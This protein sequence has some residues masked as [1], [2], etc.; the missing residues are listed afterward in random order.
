MTFSVRSTPKLAPGFGRGIK[1]V[2]E[3]TV[4]GIARGASDVLGGSAVIQDL[5]DWVQTLQQAA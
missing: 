1:L 2:V 4:P 3:R 5:L